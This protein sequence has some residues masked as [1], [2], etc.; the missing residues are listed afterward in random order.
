ME[1]IQ[2]RAAGPQ[3]PVAIFDEGVDS[4]P[5]FSQKTMDKVDPLAEDPQIV[6]L[7]Q[8]LRSASRQLQ[9]FR[10]GARVSCASLITSG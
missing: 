6:L 9:V 5:E 3:F 4:I 2:A 10:D 7:Q 1:P 8:A